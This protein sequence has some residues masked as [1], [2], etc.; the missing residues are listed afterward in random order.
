MP[1][2]STHVCRVTSIVLPSHDL[3]YLMDKLHV[4][5]LD[6][7]TSGV[8]GCKVDH[9]IQN[10]HVSFIFSVNFVGQKSYY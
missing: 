3:T 1:S 9:Y 4:F 5:L 8:D 6:G 7:D 2:P 10:L